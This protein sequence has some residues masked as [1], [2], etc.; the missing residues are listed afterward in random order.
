MKRIFSLFALCILLGISAAAA[1]LSG[2]REKEVLEKLNSAASAM[3]TMQCDFVQTKYL[4]LLSDKM[5]SEGRMTYQRPDRLRWEYVKPYSYLSVFNG[6]KVYVGNEKRRDIIDTNSNKIFKEVARIMMNTVTGKALSSPAD[7]TTSV[8]ESPAA[9]EVTLVPRKKELRGMF[10]KIVLC[11]DRSKQMIS[12]IKLY[13]KN[14]D[15]TD[16]KLKNI[17]I[18]KA[19]DESLFTIR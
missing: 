9:W 10:A 16:I 2:A 7:F 17:T 18:D 15:H 6:T 14:G 11:F 1:T 5:V 3:R 12:E 8:A 4:S 13:E 19:V